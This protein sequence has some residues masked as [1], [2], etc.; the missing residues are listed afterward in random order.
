MAAVATRAD[1]RAVVGMAARAEQKN[2]QRLDTG[3][4]HLAGYPGY[5][6]RRRH[7]SLDKRAFPQRR[8]GKIMTSFLTMDVVKVAFERAPQYLQIAATCLTC[9][10]RPDAAT[11]AAI[12]SQFGSSQVK[13]RFDVFLSHAALAADKALGVW[14]LMSEPPY[15]FRSYLDWIYDPLLERDAVTQKTASILRERMQ[16]SQCFV[17]VVTEDSQDSVWMPWELGYFDAFK[18][19]IGVLPVLQDA[20]SAF[21]GHEYLSLYTPLTLKDAA[22]MTT[23]QQASTASGA[24]FQVEAR[25]LAKAA[26]LDVND[27]VRRMQEQPRLAGEWLRPHARATLREGPKMTTSKPG[28]ATMDVQSMASTY[29][30]EWLRLLGMS[31]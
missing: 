1:A 12:Q 25:K 8:L 21:A 22:E 14:Q 30:D 4:R 28:Q 18:A 17:Y 10:K 3:W 23:R 13:D 16:A 26:Q 27:F 31:D 7:R 2:L 24:D 5:H 19:N 15:S 11:I 9:R 20:K 6:P 29:I